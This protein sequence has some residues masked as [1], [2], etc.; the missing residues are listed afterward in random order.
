MI[1]RTEIWWPITIPLFITI[2][3]KTQLICLYSP[4]EY[5]Y[6]T[7]S[8]Y[9]S[10]NG[11]NGFSKDSMDLIIFL[12]SIYVFF[13][14]HYIITMDRMIYHYHLSSFISI[15][16][17]GYDIYNLSIWLRTSID[18]RLLCHIDMDIQY[19]SLTS[20]DHSHLSI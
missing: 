9:Q 5:V 18:H 17:D 20:I 8:I 19:L 3:G 7:L 1:I 13:Y 4:Y 10:T 2:L 16:G 6:D 11:F 15:T 14:Y 12:S